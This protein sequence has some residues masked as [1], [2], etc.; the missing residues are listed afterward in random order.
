MR[1]LLRAGI[2]SSR[3]SHKILV[4]GPSWIGDMIMSQSLYMLL[5]Q[6]DPAVTIDVLAPAWTWALLNSMP[7][8]HE[9]L[10]MP[11][12]HGQF[13]PFQRYLL[14]KMLQSRH[15]HQ[16]IVLP[17][18]WK[19]AL[20]PWFAKIPKR[21]GWRGEMRYGLLNDLRIL[22]SKRYPLM[23]E[24]YLALGLPA[25]EP[26]PQHEPQPHLR[27]WP[28]TLEKILTKH[29]LSPMPLKNQKTLILCP[30][31]QYGPAK[32]WPDH[33]FA[34]VAEAKIAEGWQV[35][36]L[37]ASNAVSSGEIIQTK[38][39]HRCMNFI[40][41]TTLEDVIGLL[42]LAHVVVSN[43]SGLMHIAAALNIP[44]IAL[45]GSSSPS[46]TPPLSQKATILNQHLPCSPCFKRICPKGH[47]RCL[48]DLKPEL[49]L[50]TINDLNL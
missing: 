37:G 17:N 12:A 31:S 26:L 6:N 20:I 50:R 15:Y 5:K 43:D 45:Y 38:T 4:I 1:L 14:G 16:A 18:S 40:G 10:L 3:M 23:V 24:Q 27:L 41:K 46:F 9:P 7:E 13:K 48:L 29:A 49:V 47:Y 8:V 34:E 22:D 11:F 32:N 25:N 42:S 33:Y 21:T 2:L 35:W 39:Q 36:L 44:L 28:Q 19:S 30:G